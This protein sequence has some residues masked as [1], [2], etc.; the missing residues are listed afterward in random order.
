M[1][2]LFAVCALTF[3]LSAAAQE[4]TAV[5]PLATAADARK[6]ADKAIVLFQQ[7]KL[8]EGYAVLEPYWPLPEVEIDSL[9]NQTA[10]QWPMVKQR[11]G[12]SLATEF[13]AEQ[14][15][16]S[17]FVQFIYLQK[18]ERHAMRWIFVFYKPGDR[19]IVN[20]FSFDDSVSLL[21]N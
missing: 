1:K 7:E 10:T 14:K 16:G 19:W 4:V 12:A 17:S 11:F 15:A 21:F 8:A 13:I 9:A 3:A 6:L 20:S 2:S 5:P 18:F